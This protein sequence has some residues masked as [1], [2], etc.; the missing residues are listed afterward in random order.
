[1]PLPLDRAITSIS[2]GEYGAAAD[3]LDAVTAQEQL[4]SAQLWRWVAY[5]LDGHNAPNIEA[6]DANWPTPIAR[7][8]QG[9]LSDSG[10]IAAAERAR[11]PLDDR[12]RAAAYFFIGVRRLSSG[13]R[14]SAHAAFGRAVERRGPRRA[15]VVA[16]AALLSRARK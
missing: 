1:L 6:R 13:D 10:L 2:K 7:C 15:E 14:A 4:L 5:R 8:L 11:V 3:D 12:R 16:A 9:E